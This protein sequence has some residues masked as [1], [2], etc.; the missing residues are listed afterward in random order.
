MPASISDIPKGSLV[1]H[2]ITSGKRGRCSFCQKMVEKLEAHHIC[3]DPEIIIKLC[4]LCHHKVHYWP[5]RLSESEKTIL[6]LKRF[7]PKK[8]QEILNDKSFSLSALSQLI[9]PS[10][11]SFVKEPKLGYNNINK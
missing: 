11:S 8:T 3:Y 6:L 5:N 2:F 9:A 4:H 10:R 1:Y 7:S